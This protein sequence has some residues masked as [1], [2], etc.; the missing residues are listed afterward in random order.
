MP[1][2]QT[3]A[4]INPILLDLPN[5]KLAKSAILLILCLSVIVTIFLNKNHHENTIS[6]GAIYIAR[7]SI[8][9]VLALPTD[10]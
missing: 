5:L 7:N 3:A 1:N 6:V 9:F 2:K 8:P 4:T 10:P